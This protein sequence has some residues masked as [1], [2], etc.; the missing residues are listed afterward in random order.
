MH[1]SLV[2][3]KRHS[4][5][6]GFAALAASAVVNPARAADIVFVADFDS[7]NLV[8]WVRHHVATA[9]GASIALGPVFVSA[10][11]LT[12]SNTKLTMFVQVPEGLNTS[13]DYP[14]WSALETYGD[15][16]ASQPAIGDCITL[17][18]TIT[19][20]K[21]ATQLAPST[22]TAAPGTCG[23]MPLAPYG[24]LFVAD[25]ATDADP[26]A[27]GNQAG[28]AA[29]SLESVL[30][31]FENSPLQVLTTSN[32]FGEYRLGD[33]ASGANAYLLADDFVYAYMAV[34]G[35]QLQSVTGVLE[36]FDSATDT[37]YQ[38]LPRDASDI[39]IAP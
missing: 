38:L 25:V 31:R 13:L 39:V 16:N 26:V 27:S 20:F 7:S 2:R 23:N 11:K 15:A 5:A 3:G 8:Q 14:Q 37:V 1:S 12:N 19:E 29:E 32:I 34:A 33:A 35:T 6:A 28:T 9:T 36:Q 22:W 4:L 30:L 17:E 24:F 18:G 10:T 21:G